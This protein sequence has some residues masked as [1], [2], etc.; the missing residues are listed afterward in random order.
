MDRSTA[1]ASSHASRAAQALDSLLGRRPP[2]VLSLTGAGRRAY[3][4]EMAISAALT[5]SGLVAVFLLLMSHLLPTLAARELRPTLWIAAGL[6]GV[7][8]LAYAGWRR[9]GPHA[10]LG[11]RDTLQAREIDVVRGVFRISVYDRATLQPRSRCEIPF[12]R[13]VALCEVEQHAWLRRP[14]SRLVLCERGTGLRGPRRAPLWTIHTTAAKRAVQDPGHMSA[15][16]MARPRWVPPA[17]MHEVIAVFTACTGLHVRHA[18]IEPDTHSP[19][20]TLSISH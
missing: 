20:E 7:L 19:A 8:A 6:F 17:E 4:T 9:W 2:V 12:D 11:W 14:A 15:R 1:A 3:C 5:V 16:A 18:A 10:G 13:L